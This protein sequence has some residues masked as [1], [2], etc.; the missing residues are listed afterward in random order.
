[1]KNGLKIDALGTKEW[2]INDELHRVDG[3]A[4]EYANGDKYWYYHGTNIKV[5]SQEEF[6]R[7]LRLKAFW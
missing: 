4:I 5:S 1:M 6:L 3:P 7:M 2:Y